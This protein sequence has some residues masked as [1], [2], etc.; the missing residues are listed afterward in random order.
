MVELS[1]ERV[2]K[3][4]HEETKKTEA[5][6][7]I[8]RGIYAKYVDLYENYIANWEDLNNDKI[9]AFRKQ[10]E[11]IRSLIKYYYM[12]IPQDVCSELNKFEEKVNENLLGRDWK[13]H[14]YDAYE[15]FKEDNDEW[16][17]S[18]DYYKAAFKKYAL[19]E[20]YK[21]MEEIFRDGF[22]T[23]S[24][25]AKNVMEGISGLLFGGGRGKD[26]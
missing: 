21:A 6:T 14:L 9:D 8:L 3:I 11:E 26:R 13:M 16:D 22:G 5:L 12:D 15:K 25:T 7:T 18:E 10:N 4:L 24:Q 19:K 20:F 17:M 1:N 2:E 23:G